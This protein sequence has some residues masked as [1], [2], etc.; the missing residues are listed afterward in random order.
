MLNRGEGVVY[1]RR[2]FTLKADDLIIG[3]VGIRCAEE[4]V[5][6]LL[7]ALLKGGFKVEPGPSVDPSKCADCS[8]YVPMYV[9]G[10]EV[11]AKAIATKP[12]RFLCLSCLEQRL[13]RLL[14]FQD[15][16]EANPTNQAIH[17][18]RPR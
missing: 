4:H 1:P 15:F 3:R 11:W 17:Y 8:G 5:R 12:A 9:V 18:L 6:A 16:P 2:T 14:L 7:K 10:D 13:G